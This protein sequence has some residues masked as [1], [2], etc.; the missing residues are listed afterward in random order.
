MA[1]HGE[2]GFVD[3]GT[4]KEVDA[5]HTPSTRLT[6]DGAGD[7]VR[8]NARDDVLQEVRGRKSHHRMKKKNPDDKHELFV[9]AGTLGAV[10]VSCRD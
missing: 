10:H 4:I 6:Y 2:P 5:A 7:G 3:V 1:T 8:G 9:T